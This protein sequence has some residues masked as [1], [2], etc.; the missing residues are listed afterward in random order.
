MGH[1]A[2]NR[3]DEDPQKIESERKRGGRRGARRTGEASAEATVAW[4]SILQLLD[5][6]HLLSGRRRP[7]GQLLRD[8]LLRRRAVHNLTTR[9]PA[10]KKKKDRAT[11]VSLTGHS[12]VDSA[13]TRMA[14]QCQLWRLTIFFCSTSASSDVTPST[15]VRMRVTDQTDSKEKRQQQGMS[16]QLEQPDEMR[17]AHAHIV[18]RVCSGCWLVLT[19]WH[20]CNHRRSCRRRTRTT[21][22]GGAREHADDERDRVSQS[23]K[24]AEATSLARQSIETP[25]SARR[26]QGD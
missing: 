14:P 9:G 17:C 24:G 26:W 10:R 5:E 7:L 22:G 13:L 15:L 21:K 3:S 2:G 11:T 12:Q 20:S 23:V 19:D 6:S 16:N 1:Q 18:V 8:H 4:L 25:R